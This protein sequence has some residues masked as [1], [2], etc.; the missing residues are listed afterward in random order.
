MG[1]KPG[2]T[3]GGYEILSLIGA[4]GM[5]EVWRA[6]DTRLGRE[7]AIKVLPDEFVENADRLA[8][9]EREARVLASFN[10]PRI[11][12]IYG[13]EEHEGRMLL[14]MELASGET[15]AQRI[16]RGPLPPRE[17]LEIA[18]QIAEAL[19]AA[20]EK[21]IVHRDLK[22]A[23]V[24]VSDDGEVKVLDFGIAKVF[25][26]DE[27][28]GGNDDTKSPTIVKT[29]S[30][31]GVI[32]GT[33]A[34]MAPE[35]ARGKRVDRRADVW[36]FGATL[37]E[38]L[39][40][41]RL[42]SGETVTDTLAAVLREEADLS[43]LPEEVPEAVRRLIRRCLV[44][45]AKHRLRDIGDA[46]LELQDAL[47]VG[48]IVTDPTKGEPER[49]T[50]I[51][52]FPWILA[53]MLGIV[54]GYV[55][56]RGER[57]PEHPRLVT[58]F[59]VAHAVTADW[60]DIPMISPDGR[61]IAYEKDGALWVRHLERVEPK[62]VVGG[63]GGRIP[64]W[65]PDSRTLVFAKGDRLWRSTLGDD[66]PR[67]ICPLPQERPF[68]GGAW[69]SDDRIILAQWRGGIFTVP[70]GGG[71][72]RLLVE[73]EKGE[74]DFHGVAFLPDGRTILTAMH[75]AGD[76]ADKLLL[77]ENGKRRAIFH[78]GSEGGASASY[79]SS[80][81]IVLSRFSGIDAAVS[82]WAIPF[83]LDT[84]KT[85][86]EAFL[87]VE[88]GAHASVSADGTLAYV[89]SVRSKASQ[90]MWIS[91]AGVP[92]AAIGQA[93]RNLADPAVSPDGATIAVAALE[94]EDNEDIWLLDSARGLRTRF[95][96]S[97]A[98][99]RY[100][101]WSPDGKLLSWSRRMRFDW[102]SPDNGVWVRPVD[103]TAAEK[104]LI[105]GSHPS[106][107]PDGT[108][109]FGTR[110]LKADDDIAVISSDG[111]ASTTVLQTPQRTFDPH[112]SPDGRFVAYESNE[113]G[114][115]E[116]FV[117]SFPDT[118][119][120]WQIT[121]GGGA[122]PR[123]AKD[124]NA[125]YYTKDDELWRIP[126]SRAA[127]VAIGAPERVFS[128]AAIGVT[129]ERGYDLAPDGRFVAVRELDRDKSA[130]TIVQNWDAEVGR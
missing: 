40:A 92:G 67:A 119:G 127:G 26:P 82:V 100:A 98:E 61:R 70:A 11:A 97:K 116:I 38:M 23:N 123:W 60:V 78:L 73:P 79:S 48:W 22:P 87:V 89:S 104:R 39:T 41:K 2:V 118:R 121:T 32:M 80:G 44:K 49:S 51:A 72:L 36:A 74:V 130:L 128:G 77:I 110:S 75:A 63:D 117:S 16:L 7:V 65:S 24:K 42:F 88:D 120:K 47:R 108:I 55:L 17:A 58:R 122:E 71:E 103:G 99:D 35:Q 43:E 18:M 13:L 10:H 90:L 113:S 33:A 124:G 29:A 129:L 64:F 76:D 112:V 30:G 45:D 126:I 69:G 8:R 53:A 25:E 101:S 27:I 114:A 107:A 3:A 46:R 21:G 62:R 91:A 102:L 52:L 86:G 20:H 5:G 85:T 106:F 109:V 57:A 68:I 31:A 81:H 115:L 84:K 54:A 1:L 37:W 125:L 12:S 66:A 50:M 95:T 111:G 34:Y 4:G 15:L 94:G 59:D 28:S 19:E 6:R 96:F 105:E 56:L 9:F 93:M 14:V 83:D